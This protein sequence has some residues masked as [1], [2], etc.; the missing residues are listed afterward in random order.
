MTQKTKQI[1]I[2]VVIIVIAFVAYKMFFTGK[3]SG[4]TA[5]AVE[6]ANSQQFVDGQKILVLL[7]KLNKVI[8][9]DSIFSDKAFQSL[10]SF[11]KPLEPQ[12]FER[13]NPFLPIGAESSGTVPKS[14]STVKAR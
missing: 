9:D 13:K 5:L 4:D 12:V 10:Q 11:E 3:S 2:V 8:L 14:T 7:D 6:Q 1:I